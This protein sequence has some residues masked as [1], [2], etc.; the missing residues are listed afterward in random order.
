MI[1]DCLEHLDDDRWL[2]NEL[3]RVTKVGGRLIAFTPYHKHTLLR[4]LRITLGQSDARHGH[5]RPGYTRASLSGLL[6]DRFKL[7]RCITWV[8]PC[9][10]LIDILVRWATYRSKPGGTAQ[11]SLKGTILTSNDLPRFQRQLRIAGLIYPILW[12]FS[13]LDMLLPFTHGYMLAA[14][15]YKEI[16]EQPYSQ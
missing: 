10:Q 7:T 5:V 15:A 6:K 3:Y 14:E 9:S 12:V 16:H 8:G 13:R 11:R 1:V 4:R 2:I